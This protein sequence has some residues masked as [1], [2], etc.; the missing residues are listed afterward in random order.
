MTELRKIDPAKRQE[1]VARI[2]SNLDRMKELIAENVALANEFGINFSVESPMRYESGV[3]YLPPVPEDV[4]PE[5]TDWEESRYEDY[6]G[7]TDGWK[8]S[9]SYC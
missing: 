9:S 7:E 2:A 4:D 1:A 3:T 5:G 6:D 8:N